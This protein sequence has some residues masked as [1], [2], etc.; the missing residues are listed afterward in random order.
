MWFK[1]I[2]VF[3]IW[4]LSVITIICIKWGDV[5]LVKV[6]AMILGTLIFIL[7]IGIGIYEISDFSKLA[8]VKD[9]IISQQSNASVGSFK[10]KKDSKLR[11]DYSSHIEEGSLNL[12][13]V[14]SNNEIVE[15]FRTN[16]KSSK[17]LTIN[18]DDEY[19]ISAKY[20]DFIGAYNISVKEDW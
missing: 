2:I 1:Y 8:V 3:L 13:L 5:Y 10:A 17:E 6:R 19:A 11:I 14:D 16:S 7:G 20:N 18:R 12:S 9:N 15:E 4:I